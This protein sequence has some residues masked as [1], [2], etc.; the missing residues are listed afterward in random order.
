MKASILYQ[1]NH[2]KSSNRS[3][4][5]KK[6]YKTN[7][8]IMI[9]NRKSHDNPDLDHKIDPG[10]VNIVRILR[11]GWGFGCPPPGALGTWDSWFGSPQYGFVGGFLK[12]T[13]PHP[14]F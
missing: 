6:K 10:T 3:K 7:L 8:K 5:S 13:P 14:T 2:E 4:S 11:G 1:T 9:K 12:P